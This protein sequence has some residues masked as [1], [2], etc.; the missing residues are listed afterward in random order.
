MTQLRDTMNDLILQLRG[1]TNAGTADYTVAGIDYF[2]SYHLQDALDRHAYSVRDHDLTSFEQLDTG[3][4]VVFKEY[5][6]NW[7]NLETSDGGTARFVIRDATGAVIAGTLYSVD[8]QRGLVT[9]T[10]NQG[11]S[12]RM[13]TTTAYDIYAAA[14]DIWAQKASYYATQ[15]DFSTDNHNVKRSH[16]VAQCET[17]AKRYRDMSGT[18]YDDGTS[19][20]V[21]SIV[22]SDSTC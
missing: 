18:P 13:V 2:S 7:R 3:G 8:Y 12:S 16:I 10:S 9:F 1:M 17:M 14:A 4:T 20:S 22:R 6:A 19:G 15:I 21:V 5:Q 11:G